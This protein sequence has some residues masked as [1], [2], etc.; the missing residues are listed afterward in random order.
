MLQQ[1]FSLH[2]F[3]IPKDSE[4]DS[5]ELLNDYGRLNLDAT[6]IVPWELRF[7]IIISITKRKYVYCRNCHS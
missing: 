5:S 2:L 4:N 1:Q 7:F 3:S 6:E